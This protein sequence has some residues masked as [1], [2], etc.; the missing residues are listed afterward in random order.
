[1]SPQHAS[2]LN[3]GP[4]R[5]VRRPSA[6]ILRLCIQLCFVLVL[7]VQLSRPEFWAGLMGR[8]QT[9]DNSKQAIPGTALPDPFQAPA[10]LP[11]GMVLA[12]RTDEPKTPETPNPPVSQ[13]DREIPEIAS[14]AGK[15]VKTPLEDLPF[16]MES[17]IDLDRDLP[18]ALYYHFLDKAR[19]ADVESFLKDARRD[20]TFSHL[21]KDP[22]QDP[23]KYRGQTVAVSGIV[24]RALAFDI[25]NNAYGLKKR[26]ELWLYT[27]DSGKFPWVVE[28]TELPPG[29]PLGTEIQEKV[30]SAGYFLKLWAYRAQDGFRS[31]PVLLGHGLRWQRTD[32]AL[33][34]FENQFSQALVAFLG[35][36]AIVI[37]FGVIKWRRE[38]RQLRSNANALDLTTRRETLPDHLEI[39]AGV[40]PER[41]FDYIVHEE[42][43]QDGDTN[44]LRLS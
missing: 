43:S 34:R 28:L 19:Q 24:R 14:P 20:I 38:D 40:L 25:A 33:A 36:F 44:N 11:A 4:S 8:L 32:I 31:A 7:M 3:F 35:I 9:A 23:K 27:E 13:P 5:G 2:S 41:E 18:P 6:K 17:V 1:M 10:T 22:K 21:Y 39:Q 42:G 12:R 37:G 29:F 30:D 16:L 15:P 26:Y